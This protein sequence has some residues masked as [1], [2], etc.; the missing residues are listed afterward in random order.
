ECM[1]NRKEKS[2]IVSRQTLLDIYHPDFRKGYQDGRKYY[3]KKQK[4]LSD[5]QFVDDLQS[6]FE[7]N[8][9]DQAEEQ[10]G[11]VYYAVGSLVGE[12]SGCVIP[13]QP[14]EDNTQELQ[15]AFL[16]KVAREY[17][18]TGQV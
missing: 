2:G 6:I 12:M 3:F 7:D 11:C 17:E 5:K 18:A 4:V 15:E 1:T 14:Y 10:E 9:K 13:R 16:V 8:P